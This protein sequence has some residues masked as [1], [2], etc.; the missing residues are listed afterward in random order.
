MI[1]QDVSSAIVQRGP[2]GHDDRVFPSVHNPWGGRARGHW[3][4]GVTR[5]MCLHITDDE[6]AL[7][8]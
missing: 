4:G 2:P 8:F 6:F 5:F 3:E 1:A 7:S